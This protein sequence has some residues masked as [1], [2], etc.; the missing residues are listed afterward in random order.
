VSVLKDGGSLCEDKHI[1]MPLNAGTIDFH[2]INCPVATGEISVKL[3][4]NLLD[5]SAVSNDLITIDLSALTDKGDKLLC[6]ALSVEQPDTLTSE[7]FQCYDGGFCFKDQHPAMAIAQANS[8]DMCCASCRQ[9]PQCAGWVWKDNKCHLKANPDYVKTGCTG[10]EGL[11]CFACGLSPNAAALPVE[12]PISVEQPDFL[13]SEVAQCYDGGYCFKD[14]HPAMAIAQANS[15][16][17]CCASCN[18]DPLQTGRCAGWVWKDNKCHLKANPDYVKTG[19]TGT[20]GVN[21]FPCGRASN[22]AIA[23]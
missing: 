5:S 9:D 12:Q 2:G 8:P 1:V 18:S 22:A 14:Q 17:M 10:T 11:N 7:D 20:E 23:V 15:P 6:A 21:C 13:T 4:I 16:E 19:C 3:D